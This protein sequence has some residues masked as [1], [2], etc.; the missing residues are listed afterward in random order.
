MP[1]ATRD[2]RGDP[3]RSTEV[4]REPSL[5]TTGSRTRTT[6]WC[7]STRAAALLVAQSN[8]SLRH[9]PAVIETVVALNGRPMVRTAQGPQN[10]PDY[11]DSCPGRSSFCSTGPERGSSGPTI[12]GVSLQNTPLL[13]DRRASQICHSAERLRPGAAPGRRGSGQPAGRASWGSRDRDEDQLSR[14]ARW[15]PRSIARQ[16]P[17]SRIRQ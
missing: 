1:P 6:I 15:M 17:K 14:R 7:S 11:T 12:P 4:D 9:L 10:Q 8:P 3:V 16:R 5:P 13:P 2:D